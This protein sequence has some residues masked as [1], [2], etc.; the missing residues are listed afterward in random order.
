[1]DNQDRFNFIGL[2]TFTQGINYEIDLLKEKSIY[3]I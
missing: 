2:L 3:F 1:M